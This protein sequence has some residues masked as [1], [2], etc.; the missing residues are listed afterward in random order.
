MAAP[1]KTSATFGQLPDLSGLSEAERAQVI[2]VMERAQEFERKEDKVN[3]SAHPSR[4]PH[5][6]QLLKY[7]NVMKGWQPRYFVLEPESGMLEYFE[8]EEQKKQRPRGSVHL[9]AAV[10]SPSDEDGQTFTVNAANGEIFR[11]RALD[12]RGRQHWVDR[13][14]VTAEYH[15]AT[16]AQKKKKIPGLQQAPPVTRLDSGGMPIVAPPAKDN[17]LVRRLDNSLNKK[18]PV[19]TEDGQPTLMT[20]RSQHKLVQAAKNDSFKDVKDYISEADDYSRHLANKISSLPYTSGFLTGID[21]ELLLLKATS[22]AT[23]LC[24]EQC[25]SILQNRQTGQ[26]S[27]PPT[28]QPPER[29]PGPLEGSRSSTQLTVPSPTESFTSASSVPYTFTDQRVEGP[30]NHD[31]EVEDEAEY[32]DSELGGVEEHKSIILHLLSQLKLGMDL[33]KVVLPTFILEKRSLLEM[34]ADCMAHPDI[35]LKIPDFE[36]PEERMLAVLEWYLTSFHAGRQGSV[37]KKPYNPIIGETFHCSWRIPDSM[38]D[39][40]NDSGS[41]VDVSDTKT[42]TSS[43]QLVYCAEQVSHH[44]PVS[45]FYFEC[46]EKQMCMNA[47]I[48]TKS[49]FMGMSIGV[50]MVGKVHL[51]L[52]SHGEEYTFTLPSA[53]ARSILTVPW[54]ELGDKINITC[55]KTGLTSS[56][57]FHTKPFY[58]GKLHRVS[59]EMRNNTGNVSWKVQGEWNSN[60]DFAHQNGESK[61]VDVQ[62]LK[63]W[64][65]RVRPLSSQGEFESRRLWQH[66]TN[67]LR[68]GDVSTATEHKRFLEDRQREGE[69]HRK[70]TNTQFPSKFFHRNGDSWTYNSVLQTGQTSGTA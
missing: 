55:E 51:K 54:V 6:G 23:I 43:T 47:S 62:Q 69:R 11:L 67:A 40:D 2:A 57:V 33:T 14:R 34:F 64:R 5:E 25:L 35:F 56:V 42:T 68:I 1:T 49:K 37:A 29:K 46:P 20:V 27:V 26:L 38:I 10:I 50:V 19:E 9:A 4:K 41:D 58:G 63:I 17:L 28:P 31:D 44:P 3:V 30:V 52:L 45:A 66:V 12:P 70:D 60:L 21:K 22:S 61:S 53:Y 15:T 65:K 36:D 18:S 16:I 7:T 59:A 32:K 39:G 48:W 8:K 13:L 24:L